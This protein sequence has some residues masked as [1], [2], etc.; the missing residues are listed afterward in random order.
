MRDVLTMSKKERLRLR[1]LQRVADQVLTLK[2]AAA[3]L[4]ISYRQMKR[5]A[6]RYREEGAAGLVNRSRGEPSNHR[7]PQEYRQLV[8]SRYQASYG[9]FGPTL[10]AEKLAEEG[11]AVD[12]ETLRRWLVEA[13][14]WQRRRKRSAYRQR[15]Q[16]RARF[17][18]LVQLDGSHHEWFEGRSQGACLM[19]LVDDATGTTWSL[20]DREETTAAAMRVLWQ[21][22]ERY[23]LPMALYCDLKSVYVAIREPT[24]AEQLEDKQPLT[25]FGTACE[26]LGIEIIRAYS[27]Q[28]KGR[29]E[30]NHG[31]YQDR[32]VKELRLRSMTKI[33]EANDLLSGGFI[34]GL[35]KR[36]AKPPRDLDDA[37]VAL[38]ASV[39]LRTIFCFEEQRTLSNDYVLQYKRNLLQLQRTDL[40]LLPRPK[41]KVTVAE[42]LDGSL[43]VLNKGKEL[44]F[45][46]ITHRMQ[47]AETQKAG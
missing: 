41:Q 7:M 10:A 13:E 30:R 24:L 8:V 43:H 25:A 6:A 34:D 26:K 31:V 38:P 9:D 27:P 14:I 12:H 5:I 11:V 39:D 4:K 20:M 2:Q 16:R 19:N 3:A 28:A 29:V 45:D 22:I 23:G 21:W 42:W 15:R 46:D 37:H 36:F 33:G 32:L 40:S 17:G 44:A 18:E 47:S 35:N 1:T